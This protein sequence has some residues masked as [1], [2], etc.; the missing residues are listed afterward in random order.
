MS[1][2]ITLTTDFGLSDAFVGIMKGVMLGIAPKAKLIDLTHDIE[3]QNIQHAALVLASA[4]PY[5][6]KKTIHLVIVDPGVGTERRAIA[7]DTPRAI[8]V[9]PDN[10]VLTPAFSEKSKTYELTESPY[11]L[12]SVSNTFHGR[13]LFAPV[14]AHLATGV[15]PS[16]M[17]RKIK[18][19]TTLDLPRP[20]VKKTTLHGQIIYAD[21]FGNL[22]TNI[23]IQDIERFLPAKPTALRIGRRVIKQFV[24]TYG[25]CPKGK[26]GFL[27][28]SWNSLEIFVRN[29]NAK[30][31]FNLNP[32]AAVTLRFS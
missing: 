7:V 27:L 1:R 28:N 4:A 15:K 13:D 21:R 25:D 31:T 5:F 24:R 2:L 26:N 10:G 16:K 8:F 19:P 11:F 30:Q 29:G 17:G 12:K 23:S 14:A 20:E 9:G 3:P 18:D 32:G 6:P 22:T